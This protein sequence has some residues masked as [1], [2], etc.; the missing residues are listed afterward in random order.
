MKRGVFFS[1]IS[2]KVKTGRLFLLWLLCLPLALSS[3]GGTV[4][5]ERRIPILMY[6]DFSEDTPG[7]YTITAGQFE[8]HLQTIRDCGYT[9][10]TFGDVLGFVFEGQELPEKCVLLTTDDGYSSVLEIAVPLCE[11]YSMRLSCAV[12]GAAA[13]NAT[14]FAVESGSIPPSLELTS[15]TYDLHRDGVLHGDEGDAL[16]EKLRADTKC[17][18]EAF[19]ALAPMTREVLVYPSGIYSAESDAVY[20]EL[21][22]RIT[23]SVDYGCAV[24]RQG[25]A[26]GL[27]HLPRYAV[28]EGTSL[29][30]LKS[31]L[32]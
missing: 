9:S 32:K 28:G 15:H 12:M 1:R 8:K 21:G 22:Y 30:T 29:D 13:G 20:R 7:D 2:D 6:H 31:I 26:D 16:R 24:I 10:V 3:C 17:M 5:E 25:D 23:V 4:R 27:F 11:R 19:G 18:T 14:H